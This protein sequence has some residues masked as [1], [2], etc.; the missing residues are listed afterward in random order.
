MEALNLKKTT[1]WFIW[2]GLE[3]VKGTRK[4]IYNI[5]ISIML[6]HNKKTGIYSLNP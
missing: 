4:I 3:R 2:E 5:I 6:E 1:R